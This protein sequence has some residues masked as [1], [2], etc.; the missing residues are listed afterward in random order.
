V[1]VL[2]V[3]FPYAVH[4]C[5]F[6]MFSQISHIQAE[7]FHYHDRH[8]LLKQGEHEAKEEEEKKEEVKEDAMKDDGTKKDGSAKDGHSKQRRRHQHSHPLDKESAQQ[9]HML[10][11][12]AAVRA[13]DATQSLSHGQVQAKAAQILKDQ[14]A[15][16]AAVVEEEQR[17]AVG[18]HN[19][20]SSCDNSGSNNTTHRR[21][22]CGKAVD[23]TAGEGEEWAVH[24]IGH[25][26][27]YATDS[28]LWLHLSVGLNL[29]VVHHLFPQIGWGH[30]M[31]LSPLV[32][33]V[34]AEYGITY[35]TRP[36]FW[37]AMSSHLSHLTDVNSDHPQG[38][39]GAVWVRPF[40]E[41]G[42]TC[43]ASI[44][45][46]TTLDQLDALPDGS[47][48]YRGKRLPAAQTSFYSKYIRQPLDDQ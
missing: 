25:A 46:L 32:A 23:A 33:E 16:M 30:H 10:D 41:M 2:F 5:L 37:S 7:C 21:N 44:Q 1:A 6:Y 4:G 15:A 20:T 26:L 27:D 38:G 28:R 39:L 35:T 24:Q 9:Q 45:A 47:T 36:T 31:A 13:A 34:C 12:V 14:A 40:R 11:A 22:A 17:Q 43:T 48:T 18:G 42:P 3:L 8:E 29:Q 19:N